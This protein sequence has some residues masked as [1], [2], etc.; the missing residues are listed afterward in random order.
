MAAKTS[1]TKP[2]VKR[3]IKTGN[4]GGPKVRLDEGQKIA[5]GGGIYRSMKPVPGTPYQ[6][7]TAVKVPFDAEQAKKNEE[8]GLC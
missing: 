2:K 7:T 6:G 5:L 8:A 3:E 4:R 1:S